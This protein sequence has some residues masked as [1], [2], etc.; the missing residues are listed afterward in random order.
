MIALTAKKVP[1]SSVVGSS[2]TL[3]APEGRVVGQLAI[4]LADSRE[5]QEAIAD[6]VVVAINSQGRGKSP[7]WDDPL[8]SPQAQAIR[9]GKVDFLQIRD[10]FDKMERELVEHRKRAATGDVE[11]GAMKKALRKIADRDWNT[12]PHDPGN[13]LPIIPKQGKLG[14]IAQNV[15]DAIVDGRLVS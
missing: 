2:V 7:G 13:Y 14:R 12:P 10:L 5:Q 8:E 11:V 4:L 1:F 3:H 15:L 9:D 6:A